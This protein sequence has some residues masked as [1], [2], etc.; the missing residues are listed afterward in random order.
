MN[1]TSNIYIPT[2]LSEKTKGNIPE[3]TEGFGTTEQISLYNDYYAKFIKPVFD[4]QS[5][6]IKELEASQPLSY[7]SP[8]INILWNKC[9]YFELTEINRNIRLFI[10]RSAKIKIKYN[11]MFVGGADKLEAVVRAYNKKGIRC[12]IKQDWI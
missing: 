7:S 11:S 12:S 10:S 1:Y 6:V 3:Y 2:V 4:K 5:K 8:T 9:R